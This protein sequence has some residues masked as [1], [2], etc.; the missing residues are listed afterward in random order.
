[1]KLPLCLVSYEARSG[2]CDE[3]E[4]I[5]YNLHSYFIPLQI[6]KEI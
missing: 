3:A 6:I 2:K 1:M 4:Q 5:M